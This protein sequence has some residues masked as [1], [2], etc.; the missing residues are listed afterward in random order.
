VS[1][2]VTFVPGGIFWNLVEKNKIKVCPNNGG[3][4]PHIAK[5]DP[6]V[7]KIESIESFVNPMLAW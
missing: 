3:R 2:P 4:G 5:I 7:R 1:L 6:T